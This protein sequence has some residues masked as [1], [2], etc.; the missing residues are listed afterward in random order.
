MGP[1]GL[2]NLRREKLKDRV[3]F[4]RPGDFVPIWLKKQV[5]ASVVF[6]QQFYLYSLSVENF[7][8]NISIPLEIFF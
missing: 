6:L 3:F 5:L 4:P 2:Q 7:R 1:Q 8:K